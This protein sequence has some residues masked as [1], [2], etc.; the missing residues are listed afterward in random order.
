MK[1]R[2]PKMSIMELGATEL[3]PLMN[4][5]ARRI[6][7][8]CN[9]G[10]LV[11]RQHFKGSSWRILLPKDEYDELVRIRELRVINKKG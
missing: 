5:S 3:A 10:K 7:M 4:K 9:E 6:T 8:M 11:A 1:K 2:K